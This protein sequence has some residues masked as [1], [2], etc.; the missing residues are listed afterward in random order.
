MTKLK[1]II[2]ILFAGLS[3][4]AFSQSDSSLRSQIQLLDG[5]GNVIKLWNLYKDSAAMMDKATRLKAEVSLYYYLNRPDD[6]IR[7]VDSLLTLYPEA[8][9]EDDKFAF[10]CAKA[11]ILIERGYYKD[12]HAWWNLLSNDEVFCRKMEEKGGFPCTIESIKGLSNVSDFRMEFPDTTCT[13]PVSY[14]YPLV[15]SVDVDGTELSETIFDTGAPFTFLT[16]EAA[17][18]CGVKLIGDTIPVQSM[19]GMSKATTGLVKT[20]RVGN[21]TFHNTAVHVSLLENDPIFTGH[22]AILGMKEL[23]EVANLEFSLGNLTIRKRGEKRALDPNICFSE[24]GQLYLPLKERVYLLDTGG[25]VNFS[26]TTDS[27][28]TTVLD[29]CGYP[30]QFRNTCTANPDSLKSALLGFPFFQGFETCTLDLE[31]MRFSGE[32]YRQRSSYSDYINSNNLFGLDA[33]LEWL[34]KTSDEMGRWLTRAYW[35]IGKNDYDGTILYTDSL[36][37]K[38]QEELGGGVFFVLNLRAASLAYLGYYKEAGELMKICAQAMPDMEGSYNK[39]VALEPFGAQQ[40][41]WKKE[42]VVLKAVRDDR[43]FSVP[44]KI[45][46]N[47]CKLHFAPDKGVST[48]SKAEAVK[49]GMQVIEF[50]DPGVR[51]GKVSMAIAPELALGDLVIRNAQFEIRDEEGVVLGNNVLRLLPQ[52]A[53]QNN[54]IELYRHSQ[55]HEA[56]KEIPLLLSNYIFCFRESE[57]SGKGYSIGAPVPYAQEISLQDLC[58]PGVK[59]IFDLEHM[60]L[61][62]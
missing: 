58:K 26:N 52:F 45:G 17:R 59:V 54:D 51:G 36:L 32:N 3:L 14:T 46:E 8:C 23:R 61:G 34:E 53:I 25:Q 44:G 7:C 13:V 4:V 27:A 42:Q 15:L 19:F 10:S 30:V 2:L 16:I 40:L 56:V 37:N 48:V 55:Q 18:K 11:E 29:V 9:T 57:K 38:Y 5:Y 43:G 20:L 35:G 47:S 28:S 6:M 33:E 39:C 24:G 21:I 31:Q 50:D 62:M 12:L 41:E 22:D 49:L 1:S 60:K